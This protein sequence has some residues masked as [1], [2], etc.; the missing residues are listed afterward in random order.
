[1]LVLPLVMTSLILGLAGNKRSKFNRQ[2]GLAILYYL[3]TTLLAAIIGKL[4]V[5]HIFF[6]SQSNLIYKLS[7]LIK[8][9]S[10]KFNVD[11]FLLR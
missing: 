3:S 9:W 8:S 5:D 4:S 1:M 10:T 11:R 6:V 2:A 7:S